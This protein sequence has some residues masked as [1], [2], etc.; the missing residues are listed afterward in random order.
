MPV[1]E[2]EYLTPYEIADR[3]K[4]DQETVLRWLRDKKLRGIKMGKLWRVT[5]PDLAQFLEDQRNIKEDK[6]ED[7]K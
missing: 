7:K 3:L 5:V 6:E 4:V 1:L 2:K